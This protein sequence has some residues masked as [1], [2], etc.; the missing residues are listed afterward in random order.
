MIII[1]VLVRM[2]KKRFRRDEESML[3]VAYNF[4]LGFQARNEAVESLD[5]VES[6]SAALIVVPF[7]FG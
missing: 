7:E 3:L 2:I 1:L 6:S 5:V 4:S